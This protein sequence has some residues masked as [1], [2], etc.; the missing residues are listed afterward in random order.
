MG[1]KLIAEV[2]IFFIF[3]FFFSPFCIAL[4]TID[5]AE[6]FLE[7]GQTEEA[8]AL[9]IPLL[10]SADEGEL[11]QTSEF[12]YRIYYE[13]GEHDK[14]I[15]A[16]EAYIQKFLGT[17]TS[18]LYLYWIAKL[19]EERQNIDRSL[20]LL[21]KLVETYPTDPNFEDPYNLKCQAQEDIAYI[22][23]N[24]KK[25]YLQAIQAYEKVLSCIEKG[26]EPRIMIEIASCYEKM[27]E[28]SQAR[29]QYEKI[30]KSSHDELYSR[31]SKLRIKYLTEKPNITEKSPE[32]LAQKLIQALENKDMQAL[33]KLAKKGDFWTG[34]NFSEF[35]VDE[36]PET[37]AYIAKY[38]T[39]ADKLRVEK[40]LK[41]KNGQL[42][43]RIEN[44][45]DPEY[46]TL[47]LIIEQGVYGW[48]WKGII[49]SSTQLEEIFS[50]PELTE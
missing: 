44:W 40:D 13:K 38:L 43:L 12:L 18:Y 8:L 14:A 24:Y 9:L 42:V 45:P 36:F 48:E 3:I 28:V 39:S 37:W 19:E 6:L 31:W 17:S 29:K 50:N 46:D 20:M 21:E 5:R 22:F 25:D 30:T 16:L 47:Y 49:L 11:S 41:Q 26:E 34:V 23:Q 7:S 2:T 27:G 32:M 10:E 33:E 15:Q 35:E 1:K 4:E